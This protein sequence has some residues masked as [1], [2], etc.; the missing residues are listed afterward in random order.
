VTVPGWFL[1]GLYMGWYFAFWAWFCG[2]LRP[3]KNRTLLQKQPRGLAAT[4]QRLEEKRA[5]EKSRGVLIGSL[6]DETPPVIESPWLSSMHNLRL[7]FLLS[8][9]GSR[10]N[11]CAASCSRAG[12]GTCSALRCTRSI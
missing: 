9:H 10:R 3:S 1:V 6:A 7:A 12:A 11:T 4:T 2:V 8:L 5:A